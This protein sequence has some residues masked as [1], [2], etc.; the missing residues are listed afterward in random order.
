MV[1]TWWCWH[2]YKGEE[3]GVETDQLNKETGA[4][5]VTVSDQTLTSGA[6]SLPVS[7]C[8]SGAASVK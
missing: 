6:P 1:Y 5:Q 8:C 2:I 3:V 4:R 7:G